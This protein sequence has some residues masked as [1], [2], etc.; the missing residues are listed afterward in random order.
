MDV[1]RHK[2]KKSQILRRL[3]RLIQDIPKLNLRDEEYIIK[4]L[5]HL[6][7]MIRISKEN[8]IGGG[9]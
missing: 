4:T 7:H 5:D 1:I 8:N 9:E 3:S 6:H 2:M